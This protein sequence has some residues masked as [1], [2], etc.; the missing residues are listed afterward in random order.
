MRGAHI[1][2][3]APEQDHDRDDVEGVERRRRAVRI[4]QQRGE[5]PGLEVPQPQRARTPKAASPIHRI[6][7]IERVRPAGHVG[8]V[9]V[10]QPGGEPAGE[11]D[12]GDREGHADERQEGRV[13]RRGEVVEERRE[14]EGLEEQDDDEDERQVVD[15][16]GRHARPA[17]GPGQAAAPRPGWPRCRSPRR[18]RWRCAG[19]TPAARPRRRCSRRSRRR[20]VR[21]RRARR[22]PAGGPPATR[23]LGHP[24]RTARRDD[25]W[26]VA[27]MALM[28]PPSR[29]VGW[30]G[31][32]VVRWVRVEDLVLDPHPGRSATPR[33]PRWPCRCSSGSPRSWS[34]PS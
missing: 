11:H 7:V 18:S 33:P 2:M 29:S 25:A 19:G 21:R 34:C 30:C 24:T 23:G 13:E 15:R 8:A 5:V 9:R 31:I 1:V 4:G 20:P 28:S 26:A 22:A 32:G 27:V 3:R 10:A 6:T 17:A 16:E 14:V 12:P